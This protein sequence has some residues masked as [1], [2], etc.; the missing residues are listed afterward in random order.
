VLGTVWSLFFT[1]LYFYGP[2]KDEGLLIMI[3]LPIPI[4]FALKWIL[5]GFSK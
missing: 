1:S 3:I 4:Y 5:E 2:T